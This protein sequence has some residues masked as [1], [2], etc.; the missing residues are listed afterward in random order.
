M[1]DLE[2]RP[3]RQPT[4]HS[5]APTLR[6][7]SDPLRPR[8]DQHAVEQPRDAP[9]AAERACRGYVAEL[10]QGDVE[11]VEDWRTWYAQYLLGLH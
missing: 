9:Q 6:L 7:D 8:P 1:T 2:S 10:R 3:R 5:A 4:E 11:P